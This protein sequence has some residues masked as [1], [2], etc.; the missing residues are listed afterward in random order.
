MA[1]NSTNRRNIVVGA[2]AVYISKKDSSAG[3]AFD[4]VTTPAFTANTTARTALDAATTDWRDVGFTTNGVEYTYTPNYGEVEVDQ[5]LDAAR[6]FKQ[7]VTAT[8]KTE[9]AEATLENLLVVWAQSAG[10]LRTGDG[11]TIK[12]FNTPATNIPTGDVLLGVEAGALGAEPIERQ[13]VFV[14]PSP[15]AVV[16]GNTRERVYHLRRVVSV[17][18]STHGLKRNDSTRFPVSF[19]ILPAEVSGAEY[20]TIRDRTIS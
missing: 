9:F 16:G 17:D 5:L 11:T 12:E 10:S 8:V 7:K 6:L 18:A 20:G 15:R 19:R 3:T 4:A 13:L 2:A 14:G 1:I